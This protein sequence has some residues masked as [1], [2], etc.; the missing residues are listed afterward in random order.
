MSVPLRSKNADHVGMAGNTMLCDHCGARQELTV[1]QP[2]GSVVALIKAWTKAHAKCTGNQRA[3]RDATSLSDW[4]ESD[5]TGMSSKAIYRHMQRGPAFAED[6]FRFGG[7]R[8][9]FPL[10]PGDFG[11]CYRL[12]ALAPQWRGRMNEMAQHGGGWAALAPAW[13]ELTAVYE[14]EV[15]ATYRGSAPKLYA[16]M[17]ELLT[18]VA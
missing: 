9:P 10:D 16:R 13:D 6:A 11:R 1:P 18:S 7:A 3:F 15:G 8:V 2:V 17:K 14:A 12:L 5:D 4:P